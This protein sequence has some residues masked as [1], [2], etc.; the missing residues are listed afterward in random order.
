MVPSNPKPVAHVSVISI[1]RVSPPPTTAAT[2]TGARRRQAREAV[3]TTRTRLLNGL[4][5]K[6]SSSPSLNHTSSWSVTVRTVAIST[7]SALTP[8]RSN[9]LQLKRWAAIASRLTLAPSTGI[10][11]KAEASLHLEAEAKSLARPTTQR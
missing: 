11:R 3:T 10:G 4:L 1:W 9:H 5:A 7:S 6:F 8:R 2:R